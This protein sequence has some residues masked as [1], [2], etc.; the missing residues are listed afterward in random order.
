MSTHLHT[1]LEH[2]KACTALQTPAKRPMDPANNQ[3]REV[4]MSSDGRRRRN[5]GIHSSK[6]V[7]SRMI[8]QIKV[9]YSD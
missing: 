4:Q 8:K 9:Q 7:C 5:T 2:S 1:A 6:Q 3:G